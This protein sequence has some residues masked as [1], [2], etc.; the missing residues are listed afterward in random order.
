MS[1]VPMKS[2][3]TSGYRTK[4]SNGDDT[5]RNCKTAIDSCAFALSNATPASTVKLLDLQETVVALEELCTNADAVDLETLRT[6]DKGLL[7]DYIDRCG[8]AE[9]RL[10]K[11]RGLHK[12]I[13]EALVKLA[14]K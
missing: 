11:A 5:M 13:T 4:F 14:I 6:L 7:N 8:E 10:F 9:R 12:R 1:A 2:F 3:Q